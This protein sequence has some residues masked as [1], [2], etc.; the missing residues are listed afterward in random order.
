[1][2]DTKKIDADKEMVEVDIV[3]VSQCLEV[4]PATDITSVGLARS[5]FFM[6][7]VALG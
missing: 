4:H 7:P 5:Q 6:S 2:V 1:M 3:M